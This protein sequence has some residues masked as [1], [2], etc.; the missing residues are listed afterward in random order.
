MNNYCGFSCGSHYGARCLSAFSVSHTENPVQSFQHRFCRRGHRR[1]RQRP[2]GILNPIMKSRQL[3]PKHPFPQLLINP[4][5]SP[6]PNKV[7]P[8]P[9]APRS[10]K[11]YIITQNAVLTRRQR[12]WLDSRGSAASLVTHRPTLD[13]RDS[14]VAMMDSCCSIDMAFYVAIWCTCIWTPG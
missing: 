8:K 10:S 4:Y 12:W 13:L 6:I 5:L 14:S 3:T 1:A 7:R 9:P 11:R 2:R